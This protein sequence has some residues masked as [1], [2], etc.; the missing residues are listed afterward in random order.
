[1]KKFFALTA[2]AALLATAGMATA[3]ITTI[4]SNDFES[5]ADNAALTADVDEN[6]LTGLDTAQANSGS[7]SVANPHA[8]AT[9][10][11]LSDSFAPI[12]ATGS[13][14]AITVEYYMYDSAGQGAGATGS[15]TLNGRAGLSFA[16]YDGGAWDSGNLE[17]Y[18]VLGMYHGAT[19]GPTKYAYRVVN[20]GVGW[21]AGSVD[22]AVGWHKFTTVIDSGATFYV[23]DVEAATDTYDAPATGWNCFRLGSPAGQTYVDTWYDDVLIT[24][25]AAA[26]DDWHLY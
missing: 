4:Y 13:S 16:A 1:M 7:Q 11:R 22:R 25:A 5:Y 26:V 21:A 2:A 6:T 24:Q 12:Q 15:A 23:D 20:G 17:N 3:Q 8:D 14:D 10:T 19:D 9:G 18:I